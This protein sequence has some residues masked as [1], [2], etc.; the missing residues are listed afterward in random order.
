[1]QDSLDKIT[2]TRILN[3]VT[4]ARETEL[5]SLYQ[6]VRRQIIHIDNQVAKKQISEEDAVKEVAA[7]IN[8]V[9]SVYEISGAEQSDIEDIARA[10]VRLGIENE[11][12]VELFSD[13]LEV[14]QQFTDKEKERM[15]NIQNL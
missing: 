9:F 13:I 12:I 14:T 15:R 7:R 11:K 5:L 2:E 1:M 4:A 3:A 6:A 8:I 10:I